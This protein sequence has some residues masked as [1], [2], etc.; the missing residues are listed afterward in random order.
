MKILTKLVK[1][2]LLWYSVLAVIAI[3]IIIHALLLLAMYSGE[4][5][6]EEQA[7]IDRG[8]DV[9]EDAQLGDI[10]VFKEIL[11]TSWKDGTRYCMATRPYKKENSVLHGHSSLQKG[12]SV[13]TMACFRAYEG[14]EPYHILDTLLKSDAVRIMS[15]VERMG[16]PEWVR[17]MEEHRRH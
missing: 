3:G 15:H 16:S 14:I 1:N 17:I 7:A 13:A 9:L 11:K 4:P 6:P 10:V 12:E 5:D 8:W 2:N